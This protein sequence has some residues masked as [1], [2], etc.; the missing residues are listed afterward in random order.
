MR[1]AAL[2][3]LAFL[4]LGPLVELV[5]APYVLTGF[6]RGDDLP[7]WPAI[8]WILLALG[9]GLIAAAM[10]RFVREGEGTPS[11]LAPPARPVRGGIY[12]VL[13]HPMYVGA[14]VALVG[15][16]L[17]LRRPVLLAG[18]AAYALGMAAMVRWF[19]EPLLRR[20][21]GEGWRSSGPDPG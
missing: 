1:R 21:F 2:G 6:R 10:A 4:F 8:G 3:S 20:R 14:T 5:L 17:I 15:E 12:G 19:E 16:A 7:R 11:P 18:A 9:V 13:R